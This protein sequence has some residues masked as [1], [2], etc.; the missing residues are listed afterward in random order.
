MTASEARKLIGKKVVWYRLFDTKSGLCKEQR[1]IVD[2]VVKNNILISG[3]WKW[4]PH[5]C[6]LRL[7]E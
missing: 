2:D 3:E 6:E 1:G 5:L 7:D 4:L